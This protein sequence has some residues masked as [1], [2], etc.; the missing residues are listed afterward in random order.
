[1]QR[2]CEQVP[3]GVGYWC[4]RSLLASL[5]VQPPVIQ[6]G[7]YTAVAL[8]GGAVALAM[9]RLLVMYI[10]LKRNQQVRLRVLN[11]LAVRSGAGWLPCG[12]RSY[13]WQRD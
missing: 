11:E 10:R 7:G 3:V 8:L 1:M 13:A 2:N 5:A 12:A 9:L 4:E 6:Y